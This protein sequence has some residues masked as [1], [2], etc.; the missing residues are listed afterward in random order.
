MKILG[1]TGNIA[2]GKSLAS[3]ILAEWG[4]HIIDADTIV[5]ALY[6]RGNPV[7]DAVTAHFG[8]SV[9][10]QEGIDRAA[11]AA[12]VFSDRK[13]MQKLERMVHPAVG[14]AIRKQLSTLPPKTPAV[15]EAIRLVE[16]SSAHLIDELWIVTA[17]HNKQLDRL[18]RQR[19]YDRVTAEQRLD[20]Q[21]NPIDKEREFR[22]IRPKSPVHYL[23]NA[24]T[25]KELRTSV[26]RS[27]EAFLKS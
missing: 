25:V 13:A 27:W 12:I 8:K 11:L 20:A 1:I 15:I 4:T 18:V 10:K 26:K 22:A 2:A 14:R 6:R 19:G 7:F 16:G 3:S 17:P 24:G 23:E 5:H 21:T 9:A